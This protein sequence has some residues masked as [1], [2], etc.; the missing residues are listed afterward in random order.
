MIKL[1]R[2]WGWPARLVA[3]LAV[4]AAM[5]TSCW[6]YTAGA[7]VDPCPGDRARAQYD[8]EQYQDAYNRHDVAGAAYWRDQYTQDWNTGHAHHCW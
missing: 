1:K 6:E 2:I 4:C 7:T 3:V 8:L 5:L